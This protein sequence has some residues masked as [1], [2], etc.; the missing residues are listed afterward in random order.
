MKY[1]GLA[2]ANTS[3]TPPAFALQPVVLFN[4]YAYPFFFMRLPS[5]SNV[6]LEG[7]FPQCAQV[8]QSCIVQ[9]EGSDSSAVASIRYTDVFPSS[10]GYSIPYIAR[11]GFG[12]FWERGGWSSGAL[13]FSSPPAALFSGICGSG[14][15]SSQLPAIVYTEKTYNYGGVVFDSCG[16][17]QGGSG[18]ANHMEFREMLVENSY[19][20]VVRANLTIPLY[21]VDFLNVSY[22]D[23]RGGYATPLFDFTNTGTNGVRINHPFC[24]TAY[25]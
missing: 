5:S 15:S 23:L 6:I 21:A 4:G 13:D 14:T 25:Q 19:G 3:Q 7:I 10:G 9:D 16:V 12:F 2:G 20:P 22:S 24:A 11:G 1:K 18:G 8:Y 17:A